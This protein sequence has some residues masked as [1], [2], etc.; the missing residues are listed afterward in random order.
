MSKAAKGCTHHRPHFRQLATSVPCL[1]DRRTKGLRSCQD[2]SPKI[3]AS[4]GLCSLHSTPCLREGDLR[5]EAVV[6]RDLGQVTALSDSAGV[7]ISKRRGSGLMGT[8]LVPG[9]TPGRAG[10]SPGPLGPGILV[11][12]WAPRA[13]VRGVRAPGPGGA[14]SRSR[15]SAFLPAASTLRTRPCWSPLPRPTKG[16]G[17]LPPGGLT[18]EGLTHLCGGALGCLAGGKGGEAMR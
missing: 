10:V 7:S 17:L 9:L 8:A 13:A 3:M 18:E 16:L 11:Q 6:L 5:A 12:A 4:K 15:P 1:V 14:R 2:Y